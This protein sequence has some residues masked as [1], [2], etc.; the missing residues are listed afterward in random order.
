MPAFFIGCVSQEEGYNLSEKPV[1]EIFKNMEKLPSIEDKDP[2]IEELRYDEIF[3]EAYVA[4]VLTDISLEDPMP[5]Y[6]KNLLRSIGEQVG[7][8]APEMK[9]LFENA[10]L[11]YLVGI[12]D[13]RLPLDPEME[14]LLG[15]LLEKLKAE[16]SLAEAPKLEGL[17]ELKSA[18]GHLGFEGVNTSST[19]TTSH[20]NS[21][22]LD[23]YTQH[24]AGARSCGNELSY[25]L[26]IIE[27][28]YLRR[29]VEAG[30]RFEHRNSQ[31]KDF[32]LEQLPLVVESF[33]EMLTAIRKTGTPKE[34]EEIRGNIG[35]LAA[36][37]AYHL[38]NNLPKWHHYGMELNEW[39]YYKELEL[40]AEV[41]HAK[42]AEADSAYQYC[43]DWV[44]A[45]ITEEVTIACPGEAPILY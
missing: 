44:N 43:I 15:L 16:L 42:E 27:S 1:S 32:E 3:A 45:Q 40:F 8:L 6:L 29:V 33:R 14:Q 21:C 19:V 13:P 4:R 34:V 11:N 31:L 9:D 36:A 37:Y 41:R 10:S 24:A 7:D 12:I 18:L 20:D 30:E 2:V 25:T 5:L 17:E 28:N 35:Y 39:Y 38:R 22:A 26:G 23:I